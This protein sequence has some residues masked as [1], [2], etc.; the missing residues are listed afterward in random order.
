[1]NTVVFSVVYPGIEDYF[2]EFLASLAKQSFKNF[3]LFL[4]NDGLP[5]IGEFLRPI[6]IDVKVLDAGLGTPAKL[7]KEGIQRI[8]ESG[9][10]AIIFADADDCFDENRVEVSRNI[11]DT[12]DVVFNELILT[13]RRFEDT[14]PMIGNRFGEGEAIDH[15]C[16]RGSNCMGLTNTAIRVSSIPVNIY[17]IP[18]RIIAFDWAFFALCLHAGIKGVFTKRTATYYRQHE[19]NLACFGCLEEEQI[20]QGV[21]VKS[22]HYRMLSVFYGE[23]KALSTAFSDLLCQLQSDEA[24]KR[25]YCQAV[26][27]CSPAMPLWWEPIKTL[28]DL[29]L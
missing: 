10:E 24:M 12:K 17:Q 27:D 8:I 26:R 3:T 25:K 13:G 6:N 2:V 9:A 28:E 1:M 15:L 29:G 11:L 16:L 7:R 14:P 5:N 19:N 21:A 4:I 22:G 20:L 23:Y 18:D